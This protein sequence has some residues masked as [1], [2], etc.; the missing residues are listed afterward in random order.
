MTMAAV[1]AGAA[2][3]GAPVATAA[4]ATLSADPSN[5]ID[6]ILRYGATYALGTLRWHQRSVDVDYSFKASNCRRL[7]AY[8]ANWRRWPPRST[9]LH[10][11]DVTTDTIN[12]PVD[13]AGGPI[14]VELCFKDETDTAHLAREG[15]AHP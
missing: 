14:Y 11:N 5:P 8:D 6:P 3:V 12:V 1:V 15:Y 9:S 10:C 4:P 13:I 2:L 7:Y